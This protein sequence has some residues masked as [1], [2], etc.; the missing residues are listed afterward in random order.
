MCQSSG[1][2]P[3]LLAAAMALVS[4]PAGAQGAAETLPDALAAAYRDNAAIAAQRYALRGTDEQVP[5]ALAGWRPSVSLTGEVTRGRQFFNFGQPTVQDLTNRI[6]ALQ[7]TQPIYHAGTG[8]DID[9][10]EAAAAGGQQQLSSV[11]QQQLL[12]A[13]IAY[14]DVFRD[15]NLVAL[16]RKLVQVLTVN[17]QN[18]ES[19]FRAGTATETDTAQATA[20]R[21]GAVSGQLGAESQLATSVAKFRAVVGSDAGALASPSVLGQVPP[22]EDEALALALTC[23]PALLAARRQLDAA[24]QQVDVARG[25]LLPKLDGIAEIEHED[26][27]FAKGVRLNSAVIGVQVTVPLYES[28]SDYS[29]VRAAREAVSQGESQIVQ[30][31]RDT[32][33]QISTAWNALGAARAQQQNFHEQIRANEVALR[34][35]EREVDAGTRTRLD[36]LNAQQELFTSRINLLIAE[37][38]TMVAAFQLETAAGGFTPEALGLDVPR[39]DPAKHLDAVRDKWIGTEPPK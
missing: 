33:Q 37:H 7:I 12:A 19:T 14:L 30:A 11:E 15:Q 32:R 25:K 8:A 26:E 9:R 5:Q 1:I 21:S 16:N 38:D 10:A 28:G 4:I 23:N 18:V 24:R 17:R 34:D 29:L 35:T 27:L 2:A 13:A 31:E 6:Y 20:R 3:L 36:V 22:T 39:Y